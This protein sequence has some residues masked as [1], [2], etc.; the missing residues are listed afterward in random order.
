MPLTKDN[1][2]T[3]NKLVKAGRVDDARKLLSGLQGKKAQAALA[4]LNA[5][6]PQTKPTAN[7]RMFTVLMGVSL[8]AVLGLLAFIVA[9]R[10]IPA[11]QQTGT[12]AR[13]LEIQFA[14]EDACD[15][16]YRR[17]DQTALSATQCDADIE[18]VMTAHAAIVEE[19][20]TL[21]PSMMLA[22]LNNKNVSFGS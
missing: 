10:V 6:Y 8:V 2:D 19:C 13:R 15:E 1:M 5:R 16:H 3:V 4:K 20:Y 21:T 22:C 12:E 11:Q 9:T 14:M 17:I 7:G 18:R